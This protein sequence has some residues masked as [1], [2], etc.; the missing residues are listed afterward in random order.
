M[1]LPTTMR[2]LQQT[3]RAGRRTCTWSPTRRCRGPARARSWSASPRPGQLRRCLEGPRHVRAGTEAAVPGRFR[4]RRRDRRPGRGGDRRGGGGAR[5][6]RRRRRLRRVHGAPRR[7]G[8]AGAAGMDG[9]A[10]ARPRRELAHRSRAPAPGRRHRRAECAGPR[11]GRRHRSGR[12][13]AGQAPRRDGHRHRVA[14]AS[15]TCARRAPTTSSTPAGRPRG[16]GAAPDRRRRRRCRPGVGGRRH[17]R[18]EPGRGEAGHRPRRGDGLA[19][20][21]P[22]SPTG[23]WCTGTRSTSSAST[24]ARS[25]RPRRTSSERSCTS[26]PRSSPPV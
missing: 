7:R 11:R 9:A 26:S 6:R 21:E 24:S 3:S 25:S 1:S 13:H 14:R 18:G 20:G 4:G 16:R 5:R 15:T 17:V 23:T 2:A 19:G 8:D 10:G 12:G 22:P